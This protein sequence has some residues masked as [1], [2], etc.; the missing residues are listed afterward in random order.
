MREITKLIE[1]AEKNPW[2]PKHPS[3]LVRRF[4]TELISGPQMILE[5]HDGRGLLALAVL[6]DKINN[7]ANDACLEILGMRPDGD[8]LNI[9]SQ[10][11]EM[12]SAR[13]PQE[14]SGFQ[15]GMPEDFILTDEFLKKYRL[16][17]H[18][19]SYRMM[20]SGVMNVPDEKSSPEIVNAT[21]EDLDQIYRVLCKS[22]AQ[23][24]DTSIPNAD[25][26]KE[27]FFKPKS[28]FY[29]W[30]KSREI[31]GFANLIENEKEKSSEVRTIGVLS[32]ERGKA[33]GK[34][35]LAHCLKESRR[36]GFG[37]CY[38]S[39]AV[40]NEKALG[41]YLRAGFQVIERSTCYRQKKSNA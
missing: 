33:I 1:F 15:I 20:H 8:T 40:T 18:F 13:I 22:F 19:D 9:Y 7:P 29:L 25:T 24:A 6:L 16:L 41:L 11:I 37:E 28:H 31:Y 17:H 38:L 3:S 21:V 23:N 39:V 30:Q 32:E 10:F 36:L 26:W 4:L 5:I 34:K 35:L 14:R 27:G 12:A 2:K